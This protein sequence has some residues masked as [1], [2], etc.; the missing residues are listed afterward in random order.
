M[1]NQAAQAA[2][3][4]HN[5]ATYDSPSAGALWAPLWVADENSVS[6]ET[7]EDM[8]N[9]DMGDDELLENATVPGEDLQDESADPFWALN[10]L[11]AGQR[12]RGLYQSI[13]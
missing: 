11:S 2:A 7:V 12:R 5:M 10:E 9:A 1:A 8:K 4:E 3:S 6:A 13:A